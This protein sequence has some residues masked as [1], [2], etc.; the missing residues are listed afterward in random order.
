MDWFAEN[1]GPAELFNGLMD[2]ITSQET[3][4][5]VAGYDFSQAKNVV[6][7]CGGRGVLLAAALD[8]NTQ[9]RGILFDL[10]H[11][12]DAARKTFNASLTRRI[13]FAPGDFFKVA[14]GGGDVYLLKNI[15]HDWNDAHS[16]EILNA[17]HRAMKGQGRLVLVEQIVCEPNRPCQAKMGD[18]QMMVR[19]GGRNRTEKEYRALLG[20][21]K[22]ELTRVI[23]T[24]GPSLLEAIPRV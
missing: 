22:F 11:V 15:I 12:I 6:D 17:V 4:A 13:E 7:I 10:P 3:R 19:N 8:R 18:I 5:V 9:A 16:R 23:P 1:P 2:E 21:S 20:A 14:P 24:T